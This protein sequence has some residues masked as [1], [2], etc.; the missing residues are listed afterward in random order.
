LIIRAGREVELVGIT[1]H[2]AISEHQGPQTLDLDCSPPAVLQ[3]SARRSASEIERVDLAIAEITNQE[4]VAERAESGRRATHSPGG[5]GKAGGDGTPPK[6]WVGRPRGGNPP[7][8]NSIGVEYV[9][10]AVARTGHVVLPGPV[11]LGVGD[12]KLSVD[13]L[14]IEGC[15]SRGNSKI[16]KNPG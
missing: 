10:I 2:A 4:M 8:E 14:N 11:L 7:Q 16:G 9:D 5:V 12:E 13:I 3:L 6:G 15:E 1:A